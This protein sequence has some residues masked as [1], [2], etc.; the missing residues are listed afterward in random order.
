MIRH[1]SAT[2]AFAALALALAGCNGGEAVED[3]ERF[4]LDRSAAEVTANQFRGMISGM[5]SAMA[6]EGMGSLTNELQS[7][8]EELETINL[9][10]LEGDAKAT[11]EQI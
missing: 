11:A 4:Q 5:E 7:N 9:E 3:Q 1:V 8:M 10:N 6:D 2:L